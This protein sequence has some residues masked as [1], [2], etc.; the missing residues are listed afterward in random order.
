M[1]CISALPQLARYLIH[2]NFV[3][4]IFFLYRAIYFV[5]CMIYASGIQTVVRT[6]LALA[7]APLVSEAVAAR[8]LTFPRLRGLGK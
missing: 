6:D 2:I 5:W 8:P 7:R 1:G 3:V 4:G